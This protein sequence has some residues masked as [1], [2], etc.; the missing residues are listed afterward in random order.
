MET[1]VQFRNSSRKLLRGMIH[2]PPGRA[3][4]RG[5]P[6]VVFL[7]GFTGDRMESHW[8]FVKCS[9]ALAR[10]G[11]A[12]LRFDFYGSGESE[13]EFAEVTLQSEMSDALAAVEFFRRQRGI[14]PR[15][16]GLVGMS[17]GGAVAALV[18]QRARV[19]ALVMWSAPAHLAELAALA[20]RSAQAIPGREHRVDYNGHEISTS[21]LKGIE[22]V[23]PL[24]QIAQFRQPTLLIHPE[25]DDYI[26]RSHA[27]HYLETAG[28]AIKE[29][30]VIPGA[31]H[32]FSSVAWEH[33]AIE[34]TVEWLRT[35]L[36][37]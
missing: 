8:I 21:V 1:L 20:T 23:D 15:R 7:H 31:D 26:P 5:V 32:T 24:R 10:E 9:R 13:G 18:A 33:E 34:R 35:Y 28:A 17:L 3:G 29:L 36:G 11:I 16:T 12:S 6:G 2:R 27:S 25:K 14:N 19:Q 37:D 22:K 4:R 30:M